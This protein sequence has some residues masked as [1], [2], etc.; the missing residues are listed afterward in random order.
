MSNLTYPYIYFLF[1]GNLLVIRNNFFFFTKWFYCLEVSNKCIGEV[2]E[3]YAHN[4]DFLLS[5]KKEKPKKFTKQPKKQMSSP[6]GQKKEKV[7]EKVTLNC[8]LLL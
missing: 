3:T 2:C 7:L 4:I 5:G 6:C 8:L 1:R